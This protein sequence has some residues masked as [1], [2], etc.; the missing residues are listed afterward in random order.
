MAHW[1]DGPEYAPVER[2]DV[3]VEPDAAPLAAPPTD[4]A[5]T[6]DGP[7]RDAAAVVAEGRPDY[8]PVDAPPLAHLV[9]PAPPGRDPREAFHVASTP[10]T[11][12]TPQPAGALT[13]AP[14]PDAPPPTGLPVD[15]PPPVW[16]PAHPSAWGAA[17]AA[18]TPRAQPA[19]TP[20]Q[21]FP[22][23]HL[24]PPSHLP[25][26][27]HAWP[28]PVVNP[29]GFP[30]AGPPPWQ[31]DPSPGP[32]A[33]R[34]VTFGDMV[35]ASTPGLL[36]CLGIGALVPPLA[37]P[38]LLVASAL[39][40]RIRQRRQVVA[41]TFSIAIAAAFGLG[42]VGMVVFRGVFDVVDWYDAATGWAQLASLV[43]LLAVPAVVGDSLRR[44]EPPEDLS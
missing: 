42:L 28:P 13:S 30:P 21:P 31:Q 14:P 2:P 3:F 10:M 27:P 12:R 20:N 22:D 34:P 6:P 29:A 9:P 8:A 41:R 23:P 4:A 44:G 36:I 5:D 33:F 11:A 39:A 17:H 15:L 25:P 1:T 19:W 18:S 37:I 43:L 38:L 16:T 40:S 7:P 26:P 32:G 24:A 35:R